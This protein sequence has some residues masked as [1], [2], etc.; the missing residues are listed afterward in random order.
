MNVLITGGCGFIGANLVNLLMEGDKNRI[1][2]I[3]NLQRYGAKINKDWLESLNKNNENLKIKI[4]DIWD[5]EAIKSY[6]NDQDIIFHLAGQVSE[7]KSLRNP[8]L[9]FRVNAEGTLNILEAVRK[10]NSDP[11]VLFTSTNKVYGTLNQF[12]TIIKNNHYD[13]EKLKEGITEENPVNFHSPY[14]CSKGTADLYMSIYHKIYGLK[15]IVFRMS[16]IYGPRQFGD[17][18]QGWVAHFIISSILNK[19]LTIF[20]DGRQIRDVLYIKDLLKA[21]NLAL[22]NI[23]STQGN[24]YN[25]G[26]GS[27]NVISLLELIRLLENNLNKKI[28]ISYENWRP[29]DQKV[30]YSNIEK[31]KNDFGWKPKVSKEIGI[32]KLINWVKENKN[33]IYKKITSI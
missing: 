11:A 13:F 28:D 18:D 16:C 14:G 23:K 6:F 24:V 3:D 33:L 26:G 27:K 30:Y 9:D 5:F 22:D 29:G 17:E 21:M 8:V 15:T 7:I 31:A 12:N 19:S 2:V 32:V 25:I 10:A 4:E 1:L 20:G